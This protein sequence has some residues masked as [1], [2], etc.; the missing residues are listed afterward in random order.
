MSIS[1]AASFSAALARTPLARLAHRFGADR[2]GNVVIMFAFAL[3]PIFGAVGASVDYA[4]ALN[5]RTRMQES[6]DSATLA[7]GRQFQMTGD[8]SAADSTARDYFS[9][10]FT[11]GTVGNPQISAVTIDTSAYT[12]TVTASAAV[13]TPFLA[14][15]GYPSLSVAVRS[16]SSLA[17]GGPN[18][19][20]DLELALML[21]ITGSMNDPSGSGNSKIHD[22]RLAAKDVVDIIMPNGYVGE[23]TSRIALVPFS[24]YVNVGDNY[25]D[26]TGQAPSGGNTC[27]TERTGDEAYTD[28][29]PGTNQWIGRFRSA[30][31]HGDLGCAPAAR[32][33]P[34]TSD[35]AALKGSI[36]NYVAAG[37]T[38]GH[39][40]TAWAWYV[41]SHRWNN[42]WPNGSR[43]GNGS[44]VMKVAVLMTDGDY[45]TYYRNGTES[46]DQAANLCSG[47]KAAGITL[48]TVGFGQGMSQTTRDF[49]R[50]CA[51]SSSHYF[52]AQNGDQ[53]RAA[54]RSIAFTLSH[55]R[56][57][58]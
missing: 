43:P 16:Q 31:N 2:S 7:G 11:A 23:H 3:V 27:V 53:L 49:L 57:T 32:I 21:D 29:Q 5:L 38:A 55:L 58:Q 6:V 9:H 52:D 20:K 17:I 51:S 56:I 36:D 41:L 48:Y 35:K 34:L 26:V 25:E 44:N 12:I 4:R 19:D 10:R 22:A 18:A 40:G 46:Q 14:V 15:M 30:S 24:Q 47:M 37:W 50:N 13:P 42:V 39:L 33:M 28:A 54:F 45:N 8:T 1:T